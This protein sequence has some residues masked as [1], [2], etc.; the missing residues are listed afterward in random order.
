MAGLMVARLK[1]LLQLPPLTHETIEVDMSDN[2]EVVDRIDKLVLDATEWRLPR[3]TAAAPALHVGAGG[4]HL[5]LPADGE[6][7]P[8]GN[9]PAV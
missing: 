3:D 5:L 6:E 1:D 2:F 8:G 4:P 7:G 9:T